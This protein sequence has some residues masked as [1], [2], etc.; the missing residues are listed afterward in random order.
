MSVMER[1]CTKLMYWCRM[2]SFNSIE[3]DLEPPA[4]AQIFEGEQLAVT[5][6][7]VDA[8][9]AG[10]CP[11]PEP[12][13]ENNVLLGNQSAAL[14]FAQT[15]YARTRAANR[16]GITSSR[17]ARDHLVLE[18]KMLEDWRQQGFT[19]AVAVTANGL[20]QG[21]SCLVELNGE[22]P[23]DAAIQPTAWQHLH[24]RA[25]NRDGYPST[26]MG[27]LAHVRQFLFD[28]RRYD[29]WQELVKRQPQGVPRPPYDTDLVASAE[30]LRGHSTAVFRADQENDILRALDLAKQFQLQ[31]IIVGA[32]EG[33]RVLESLLAQKA[34]VIAAL[35]FGEEP[36]RD[37]AKL[38]RA[39]DK[40]DTSDSEA[41]PPGKP[42]GPYAVDGTANGHTEDRQPKSADEPLAP[43]QFLATEFEIP[44]PI[45][46]EPLKVFQERWDLWH[47]QV[48]NVAMM[49]AAGLD[50]ALTTEGCDSPKKFRANL[51]LALQY[52]LPKEW[53]LKAL[54]RAPYEWLQ[55]A[56]TYGTIAPAKQA[57]LIVWQGPPLAPGSK[58]RWIIT[59][60]RHF[61]VNSEPQ[62]GAGENDNTKALFAL[63]SWTLV[64]VGEGPDLESKLIIKSDGSA[65]QATLDSRLGKSQARSIESEG[66][67]LEIV[68]PIVFQ[69]EQFDLTLKITIDG[70]R[71]TGTLESPFGD[72]P[73]RGDR[74][75]PEQSTT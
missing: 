34:K 33:H 16:H 26:L 61:E 20:V 42:L 60:N 47:D 22:I 74:I 21:Q 35:A 19:A 1:C 41:P 14:D 45:N 63:G 9:H 5:A 24:L 58:I 15:A 46:A 32:A 65:L 66:N 31:P 57:Q 52:G 55:L 51:E 72:Q 44:D 39:S 53:A 56:V 71:L 27:N 70:D 43:K 7:W 13:S 36:E 40:T 73:I 3:K 25:R 6:G 18:K 50:L 67:Q 11:L 64:A 62:P 38:K 54:S 29:R 8:F 12:D 4:E 68:V 59:G 49:A 30:W 75:A 10:L 28:S 48:T 17:Q 2:A 37:G 69:S 23:R